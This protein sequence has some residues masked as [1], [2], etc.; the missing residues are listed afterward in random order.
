MSKTY[1]II[2]SI[3][4]QNNSVLR[5]FSEETIA[6]NIPFIV[7]GDRKSPGDFNLT[8][9]DYY[10]LERQSLLHFN[11]AKILP[12]NHYTR[13]NLGYLIAMSE[14]AE[15]ILETDDDNYPFGEFWEERN[16]IV[17]A[18][19]LSETGWVNIYRYFTS[20]N[21]WP[22][23]CPLEH[24]NDK[25]PELDGTLYVKCPIQQGL[26]DQNPDVDAIYRLILPL[27]VNFGKVGNIAL[28]KNSICPF[29]SQN[30]TWFSE[31][32]RLMYLPSCCSFRMTDIWRSF[33]AQRIA[34]SCGWS[35]LFHDS[36]VFQERNQH[37]L[38]RDFNDEIPGYLNNKKILQCLMDID[39]YEGSSK[40]GENM[41]LCYKQLINEGFLLPDELI[42][43]EAWLTDID[44]L[45]NTQAV[46]NQ[47]NQ[48]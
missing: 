18:H 14:G 35:V 11:L 42:M 15:R 8:G 3:A 47:I 48:D 19:F 22:R 4:D 9:C 1:L 23:G 29:N 24:I 44:N 38:M 21:I 43:L 39:L 12:V 2:T 16:E 26:A 13:K 10:S 20:L 5:K 25:L 6:R 31:A 41:I 27:P 40:I 30:T 28:G 34:W 7:M 33:V 36:S 32:F 37:N 17:E 45:N 46:Q